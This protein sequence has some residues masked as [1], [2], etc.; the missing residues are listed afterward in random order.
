MALKCRKFRPGKEDILT[1]SYP[2]P[3]GPRVLTLPPITL[4]SLPS[5]RKIIESFLNENLEFFVDELK[6]GVIGSL[7]SST[8]DEAWRLSKNVSP[9]HDLDRVKT[10][11]TCLKS[12]MIS[13]ALK[14]AVLTRLGS[15]SFGVRGE[16]DLGIKTDEHPLSPY[17]GRK[18]V[19]VM[20]DREMFKIMLQFMSS[21][22]KPVLSELK[23]K[24]MKRDRSLWFEIFLTIFI[25][26]SNLEF[27]YHHQVRKLKRHQA[28]AVSIV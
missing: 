21:K 16:E 14:I 24:I 5:A 13:Q 12:T 26:M 9:L 3:E 28:A 22:R 25:L 17:R 23:R 18:P 2:T 8:F 10:F 4:V 1:K 27:S 7:F 6:V 15:K 19:P 11:L 20:V